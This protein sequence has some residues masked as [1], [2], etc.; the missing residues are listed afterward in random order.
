MRIIIGLIQKVENYQPM[1]NE[2]RTYDMFNGMCVCL[3]LQAVFHYL[4]TNSSDFLTRKDDESIKQVCASLKRRAFN[5]SM[6]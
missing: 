6:R 5:N 1:D 4:S 2:T 3:H